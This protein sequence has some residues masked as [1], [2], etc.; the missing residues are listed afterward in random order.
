MDALTHPSRRAHRT[1][2]VRC[3]EGAILRM[4]S[5]MWA[6]QANPLVPRLCRV[7]GLL[8]VEDALE[9][10]EVPLCRAWTLV[11]AGAADI[12][13]GLL[14]HGG[15]ELLERLPGPHRIDLNLRR[16]LD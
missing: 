6:S 14:D 12:T 7:V 3:R 4:R 13:L 15:R 2:Q 8:A 1:A 11:E 16:A 9:C 5:Q 10:I